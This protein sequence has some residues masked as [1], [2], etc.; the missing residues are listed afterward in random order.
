MKT[1]LAEALLRRK[2]LA[3]KVEQ[4]KTINRAELFEV[5]V[6]RQAVTENIEHIQ[7]E[8]PKLT[9]KQVTR[10]F[11]FYAR[12]L[13]LIDAVIQQ[14]NWTT[15]IEVADSTFADFDDSK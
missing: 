2:E 12:N 1:L 8:V 10:E 11:D 13:R 14:Q 4:L 3:A 5:K 7:A 15:E 6:R 9:A